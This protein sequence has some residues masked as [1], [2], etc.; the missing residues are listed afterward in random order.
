M[1]MLSTSRMSLRRMKDVCVYTFVFVPDQ[2]VLES[3]HTRTRARW[4]R[5]MHWQVGLLPVANISY[6]RRIRK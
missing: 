2:F 6:D 1:M 5:I 4:I 3:V